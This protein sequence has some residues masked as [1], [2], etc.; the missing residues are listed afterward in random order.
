MSRI[1]DAVL[2]YEAAAARA[3]LVVDHHHYAIGKKAP[4]DEARTAPEFEKLGIRPPPDL[5]T[6]LRRWNGMSIIDTNPRWTPGEQ[7]IAIDV[8]LSSAEEIIA[9]ISRNRAYFEEREDHHPE[10]CLA[11]G[12]F[13]KF[14][15]AQ[16]IHEDFELP[17]TDL[18]FRSDGAWGDLVLRHG[19]YTEYMQPMFESYANLIECCA[20][21]LEQGITFE[22]GVNGKIADWEHRIAFWEL[23]QRRNPYFDIWKGDLWRFRELLEIAKEGGGASY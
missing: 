8:G 2:R 1:E 11:E 5:L 4:F 3:G 20:E 10:K 21:A 17:V 22:F 6:H 23:C 7:V 19:F 9:N 13:F 15:S 14:A 18:Y 12:F 16:L